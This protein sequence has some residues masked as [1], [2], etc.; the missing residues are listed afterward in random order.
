MNYIIKCDRNFMAISNNIEADCHKHWLIQM[1]L[2]SQN[3]LDIEVNGQFIS[4]GAIIVN[5]DTLHT[6]NTG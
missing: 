5:M 4:C 1:F 6:F 3:E 2:G